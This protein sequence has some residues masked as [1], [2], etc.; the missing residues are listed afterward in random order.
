M[1]PLKGLR[2][3]EAAARHL[4]FKKAA[5]ELGV[6]ATAVSHAVHGLER[7]CGAELFRRRPRPLTLTAAGDTLFPVVRDAFRAVGDAVRSVRD[8][9]RVA[10]LRITA[11]NA[12][13]ARW[14]VPRLPCWREFHPD[15]G[16]DVI[17]TDAVLDL[18][19]GEADV[20]IRYA[21]GVPEDPHLESTELANDTFHLVASPELI[22]SLALPLPPA[23][24]PEFPLIEAGWPLSDHDAPTWR[25]W[26][27]E[28]RVQHGSVPQLAGRAVVSFAEE[29]HAIE[30]TIAGQGIAI[31]SDVL[32]G[33]ELATG[34]LL[35]L[36]DVQLPG[37]TFRA[38]VRKSSSGTT[39]VRAFLDWLKQAMVSDRTA[40]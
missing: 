40:S 35:R 10:R 29:L 12:F 36:S 20:A 18:A 8:A 31:C 6:T 13:A 22:G 37:Y 30:A 17:G 15:I 5:E 26:E 28:A 11:T 16:L 7:H 19:G 23:A 25:R 38:V 39:P 14:L 32:V 33:A 24:L 21:R 1:P 2:A 3:F 27:K 9:P 4:S 34:R